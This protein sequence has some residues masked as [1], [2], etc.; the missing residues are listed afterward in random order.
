MNKKPE[1]DE[2]TRKIAESILRMPPKPHEQMK[3][4]K[5]KAHRKKPASKSGET[6]DT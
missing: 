4:G 6:K 3:V 2:A 1:L 5:A